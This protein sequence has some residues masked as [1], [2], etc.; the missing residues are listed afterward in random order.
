MEQSEPGARTAIGLAGVQRDDVHRGAWLVAADAP[1][2]PSQAF[3]AEVSLQES[4]PRG[5][6]TRSRVR[7]HLGTAEVMARLHPRAPIGPGGRGIARV[8][9]EAPVV[10]RAEDRF[11][12]R[13]YSPVTTIGGGR[14]LDPQP[15]RRRSVW[16]AGLDSRRPAERFRALLDRRPTGIR[17]AELPVLLGLPPVETRAV[18][19]EEATVATVGDLWVRQATLAEIAARALSILK[20]YHRMHPSERGIPLETLRHGL[21]AP[22]ACVW[23]AAWRRSPASSPGSREATPRSTASCG[24]WRRPN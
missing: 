3:D 1:W 12:L 5:L 7:V 4:A 6:V 23:P 10:A 20:A 9:L 19:Q 13:S 22:D 17:S 8:S 21:R 2:A 11:V 15:P 24:S 18:A 16:P 14:V